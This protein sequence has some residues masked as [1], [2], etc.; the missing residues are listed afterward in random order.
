M[1]EPLKNAI[2]ELNRKQ[3]SFIATELGV[4]SDF[5]LSATESELEPIYDS[6]CDIECA[7]IDDNYE[8]SPRGNMA[9]DIV[10]ILGNAIA[11]DSGYWDEGDD[12]DAKSQ[13]C[14]QG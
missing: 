7:E 1:G 4:S 9:A 2:T 10:T 8:C 12:V 5:I 13:P 11:Q 6:L 14:F 3:I